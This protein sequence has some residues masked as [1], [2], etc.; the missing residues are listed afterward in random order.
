L[1]RFIVVGLAIRGQPYFLSKKQLN[2]LNI[3]LFHDSFSKG[4][5]GFFHPYMIPKQGEKMA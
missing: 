4:N 2:K 5:N 3:N 1:E